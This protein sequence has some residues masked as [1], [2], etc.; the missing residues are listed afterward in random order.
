[1]KV[2]TRFFGEIEFREED[3]INFTRGLLG[4]EDVKKYL[5]IDN[6]DG[7]GVFKW[8]QSVDR[9]ELA[10]VI[11]N[12]FFIV[13]D[14]Q[15]DIPDGLVKKLE[16]EKPEDVAVFT[17]VV[18]P[19]DINKMTTNLKAPIILNTRNNRAIQMVLDDD[20][21]RIK[22]PVANPMRNVG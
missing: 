21:Y 15:F 5:I 11:M 6:L 2:E 22:H 10:F 13:P 16:I 14:Y 4:F 1:M 7:A 19:E 3:V 18:V 8:L 12:P 17:I 9:P 20:R